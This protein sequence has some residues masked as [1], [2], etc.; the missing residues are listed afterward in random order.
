MAVALIP[1]FA[2]RELGRVLGRDR[3]RRLLLSGEGT[4]RDVREG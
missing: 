4:I 1:Y 2:F 3:L